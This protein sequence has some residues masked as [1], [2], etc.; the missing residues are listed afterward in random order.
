[1]FQLLNSLYVKHHVNIASLRIT[2]DT[3]FDTPES[4]FPFLSKDKKVTATYSNT[5]FHPYFRF[6]FVLL[7]C[8][9][10]LVKYTD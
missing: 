5:S 10:W 2:N 7:C 4:V 6:V 3:L 8:V 1:M 9:Q